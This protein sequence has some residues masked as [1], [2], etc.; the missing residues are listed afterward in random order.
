[1]PIYNDIAIHEFV[2]VS[3]ARAPH[4]TGLRVLDLGCGASPYRNLCRIRGAL[5]IGMDV[6]P[7]SG[8]DVLGD[9]LRVPFRDAS[10]HVVLMSEVI[11]HVPDPGKALEEVARVLRPGGTLLLTWPFNYQMHDVPG[12]F[13][14]ITEFGMEALAG[15]SGL[16]IREFRRSGNALVLASAIF[17]SCALGFL[18]LCGKAPAIGV[19][20]GLLRRVAHAVFLLLN[21]LAFRLVPPC[22]LQR[23]GDG[24]QGPLGKLRHWSLG[25]CA[26]L[27]KSPRGSG[28]A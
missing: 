6:K 5:R 14:R 1:M 8:T 21:L 20:S 27:Q 16:A 19:L 17:E 3:L 13:T 4:E 24:L 9:A 18:H 22:S 23:P 12:D 15:R 26:R 2:R 25:Y 28:H 7:Q 11:E 10:F